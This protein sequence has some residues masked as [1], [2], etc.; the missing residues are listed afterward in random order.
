[1]TNTD[2]D[3]IIESQHQEAHKTRV[4]IVWLIVGL[5][6]CGLLI[7]LLVV[8]SAH[9]GPSGSDSY[10]WPTDVTATTPAPPPTFGHSGVCDYHPATNS[11]SC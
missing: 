5:P 2:A 7:W 9:R 4:L 8:A 1:M 6:A 10:T 11:Y 3:R